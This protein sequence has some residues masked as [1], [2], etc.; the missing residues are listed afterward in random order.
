V[1]VPADFLSLPGYD[2]V[3][4]LKEMGFPFADSALDYP[5]TNGV[6]PTAVDGIVGNGELFN[7]ISNFLDAGAVSNLDDAFT[8][9]AWVDIATNA[10][11]IQTI[12]ANKK[13]G[14]GSAGFA[15]F[16]DYYQ[17]TNQ[18][19]L[20]D[21]GDGTTGSEL[22][23]AAGAVTFGQWHLITAAIGR[24]NKSVAFYVDGIS[25]PV[26]SGSPL[27]ADFVN[28]ADLNLG[29]LTNSF[30]YFNGMIDE[31]RIHSGIESSN[32]VWASYMTVA[33]NSVW[34]AYS[35]VTNSSVLSTPLMIQGSGNQVVLTWTRG[36]LQS[37]NVLIGPYVDVPIATSPYTNAVSG[38]QQFYRV[39]I[40]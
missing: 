9:S 17:T 33:S 15:L 5:A 10:G 24:T 39:R 20:L 31:A 29:R 7:G 16:V 25:T 14:Y 35:S 32:W 1:W 30:D 18:A 27:V 11:S 38:A 4:H 8:L 21:T 12:W 3:W 6:A 2:L 23:T 37:A 34:L 26:V 40:Q 36:T 13:G 19:L 28:D 22:S